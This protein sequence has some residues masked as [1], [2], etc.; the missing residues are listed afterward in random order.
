[1]KQYI[2]PQFIAVEDKIIGFVTVRQFIIVLVIALLDVIIFKLADFSLFII[3]SIP[4][5]FLAIL[6]AFVNVN[7][8]PFHFFF[9]NFIT[10][11]RRSRIRI[12]QGNHKIIYS[13]NYDEKEEKKKEIK[14]KTMNKAQVERLSKT[15]DTSG[16]YKAEYKIKIYKNEK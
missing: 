14:Y 9:L 15:V 10:T 16:K 4:L 12:W 13:L 3:L 1:M 5:I 6:F 2:V 8:K 11:I 7:G